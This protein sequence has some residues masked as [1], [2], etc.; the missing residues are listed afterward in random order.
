MFALALCMSMMP[1]DVS[2]E[3]S[4]LV[5]RLIYRLTGVLLDELLVR[6]IAHFTEYAALGA[7]AGL[8]LAQMRWTRKGAAGVML[9]GFAAAF[10]D[11]TVQ[12]FTGRGPAIAD[13]WIDVFGVAFG[14]GFVLAVNRLFFAAQ[15]SRADIDAPG[16]E[17][18]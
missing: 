12:I 14:L 4:G 3:Q 6:K 11:E 7:L 10:L 18:S 9:A 5:T 15:K 16:G 17:S 2:G 13:V 1:G 8:A